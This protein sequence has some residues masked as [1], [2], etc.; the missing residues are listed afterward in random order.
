LRGAQL[1]AILVLPFNVLVT[2]PTLLLWRRQGWQLA[3][4]RSLAFWLALACLAL[5]LGLMALTIRLFATV[6][7]GTLAPWDPTRKLV[8]RGIYRHVRN[9][10][11]TGVLLNLAAEALV[12]QSPS[13][14]VWL[15][16]FAIGNAIYIPLVE[17][18]G[19]EK[20]FG[21]DYRHYRA[22]VPRW[23]P[24]LRAYAP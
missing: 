5:G 10:M 19:L 17:E 13:I 11:I 1:R 12:F 14:G 4:P 6:G 2:I 7:E 15:A 9:P 23:I 8:V 3:S 20:R 22:N 18:R 16:G 21:D 24:R